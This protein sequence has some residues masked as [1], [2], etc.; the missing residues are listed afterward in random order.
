MELSM[1]HSTGEASC[2]WSAIALI[3]VACITA[4]VLGILSCAGV[5]SWGPLA[6]V[7]LIVKP[8]AMLIGSITL[9]ALDCLRG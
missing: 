1:I 7:I 3:E 6:G 9:I 5:L 4:V 8:G 2:I